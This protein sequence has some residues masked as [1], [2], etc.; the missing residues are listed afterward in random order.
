MPTCDLMEAKCVE[1]LRSITMAEV[2]GVSTRVDF[3]LQKLI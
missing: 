3:A 2:G 1:K